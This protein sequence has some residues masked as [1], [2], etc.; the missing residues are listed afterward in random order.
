MQDIYQKE[1]VLPYMKGLW[2]EALQSICGLSSSVFNGKHQS[3]PYC[4]GKDRF[5]WTD[6]LESKGDGGAICN[7]CGNDK[8]IGWVMKLT[9]EPYTEVINILGR[10]LGKVP[11]E[12]RV[13]ANKRASRDSGYNFGAQ[14]DHETCVKVMERTEKRS[15]TPLS[16]YEGIYSDNYDVGIKVNDKGDEEIFHTIPCHLVHE[17]GLDDEYCNILFIDDES[18][19]KFLAREYTRGSVCKV[20]SGDGAIYLT[21]SWIDAVH[22]QMAT[23]QEVWA[24]FE[25]SNLEMVAHRYKGDRELRVAC[26]SHDL[27]TL[28]MADER[29]LKVIMPNLDSY[30]SGMIRKVFEASSLIKA[31]EQK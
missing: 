10:F 21:N 20:G 23:N 6:K 2:R 19:C 12:Y 14:A 22:V 1:E 3:C 30:K 8:G 13:K 26:K 7:S 15:L 5:R 25:P 4:G 11:Q 9:G 18:R 24:C 16:I 27:E 29:Q 28:Y 31:V 17:D